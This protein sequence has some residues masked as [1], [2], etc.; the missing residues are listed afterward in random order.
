MSEFN[1]DTHIKNLSHE[2]VGRGGIKNILWYNSQGLIFVN[3]FRAGQALEIKAPK[4][5]KKKKKI[6]LKNPY[7]LIQDDLFLSS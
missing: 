4:F 2:G 3:D 5:K 7:W 6:V 1:I